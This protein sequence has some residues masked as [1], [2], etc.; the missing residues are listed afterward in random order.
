MRESSQEKRL[1]AL[2]KVPKPHAKVETSE[3]PK[4]AKLAL[5]R[6]ILYDETHEEAAKYH[7]KA[8]N[9]LD[10]YACSPA[11]KKWR[12]HLEEIA[13]DPV[14]IAEA[15]IRASATGVVFDVF[16]ALETA[17]QAR[18]F[19]EVG[20]ITRDL[21]NRIPELRAQSQPSNANTPTQIVIN[22]GGGSLE[23]AVVDTSHVK[24]VE[25]GAITV[26]AEIVE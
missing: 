17:K 8:K 21:M 11:G 24:S 23:P 1:A 22:L 6:C 25:A 12:A 26:D 13:D 18:D 5:A 16:W 19:A 9:T 20:V 15:M 14:R 3:L 2:H 10:Q 7:G 4:W